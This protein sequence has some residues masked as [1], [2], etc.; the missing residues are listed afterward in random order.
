MREVAAARIS[1][2]YPQSSRRGAA[3]RRA[4]RILIA[5]IKQTTENAKV[6]I[7]R[8]F[9]AICGRPNPGLPM[10]ARQEGGY[11]ALARKWLALAERRHA[12]LIE[13]RSS[14]RWKHY[15]TESELEAQLR[16][17]NLA[18]GRFAK[19]AGS[20]P[21]MRSA[22]TGDTRGALLESAIE[23]ALSAAAALQDGAEKS[24]A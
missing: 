15:F 14:G 1:Q 10:S 3:A 11:H 6:S 4:G 9:P 17:L 8:V 21:A 13:L 18:R 20:E 22:T 5:R 12:H 24:A 16:E 7:R 19:V 2:T 23:A